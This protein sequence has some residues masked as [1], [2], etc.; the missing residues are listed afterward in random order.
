MHLAILIIAVI[1]V[2]GGIFVRNTITVE[3]PPEEDVVLGETV[4][5]NTPIPTES[6]PTPT[7]PAERDLAPPDTNLGDFIYPGATTGSQSDRT[8]TLTSNDDAQLI[9]D[10]Y[11]NKMKE[12]GMNTRSFVQTKTNDN[13]NNV[14]TAAKYDDEINVTITKNAGESLVSIVVARSTY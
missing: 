14:L 11:K 7:S 3:S 4:P 9:T 5:T 6:T 12:L 1:L 10:W 8:M 2:G 13:V